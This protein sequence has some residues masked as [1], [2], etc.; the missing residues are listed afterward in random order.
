M[1]VTNRLQI[2]YY[3]HKTNVKPTKTN[4]TIQFQVIRPRLKDF[5]TRSIP[6]QY[7][8]STMQNSPFHI[9]MNHLKTKH[10]Q[11][12]LENSI[13]IIPKCKVTDQLQVDQLFHCLQANDG[14]HQP[15]LRPLFSVRCYRSTRMLYLGRTI[16]FFHL[17]DHSPHLVVYPNHIKQKFTIP[18]PKPLLVKT[19]FTEPALF[20]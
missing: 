15:D 13:T 11:T 17:E 16:V 20:V 1:L 3:R 10:L 4:V 14:Y 19:L 5:Q 12:I 18:L 7:A 9:Q 8:P 6:K 2:V